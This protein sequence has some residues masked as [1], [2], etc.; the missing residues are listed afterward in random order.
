MSI[1]K[2]RLKRENT[3]LLIIDIQDKLMKAMRHQ[4]QIVKNDDL[5]LSLA[6][7]TNLPVVVTEQYPAG[8]QR[9][10]PELQEKFPVGFHLVEKMSFTA[11]T[12][13]VSNILAGLNRPNIIVAGSE[14]HVCVYQTVRDLLASGYNVHLVQDAVCSRYTEN[15]RSGVELMRDMGAVITNAETV[16]FDILEKS[17]TEEFKKISPLLK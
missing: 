14:T 4:E 11:Y 16:V 6:Q 13:E 7:E 17:G 8:L 10:V 9:I 2:Y 5:L 1:G 12:N 15:F 3:V